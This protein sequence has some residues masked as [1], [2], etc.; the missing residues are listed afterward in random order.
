MEAEEVGFEVESTPNSLR[1]I[2]SVGEYEKNA[3][4]LPAPPRPGI[5]SLGRI[6]LLS[7]T[8]VNRG[9]FWCPERDA[10]DQCFRRGN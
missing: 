1:T 9:G 8:R 7:G 2:L 5:V 4:F 3:C 10:T 6:K